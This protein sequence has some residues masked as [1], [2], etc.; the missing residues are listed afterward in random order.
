MARLGA[1]PLD[2]AGRVVGIERR[3]VHQRDGLQEPGGLPV[4]LHRAAGADGRGAALERRAVH[5]HAPDPVE[6]EREAG[7]ALVA[8]RRGV[9]AL[10]TT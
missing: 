3:Q 5:A 9:P 10:S 6:I 2:A 7:I 8:S 1:E 4:L